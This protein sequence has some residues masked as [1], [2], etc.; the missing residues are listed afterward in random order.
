MKKVRVLKKMPFA[1][2][3]EK[4]SITQRFY[5]F[6]VEFLWNEHAVKQMISNGWL[7]WVEE[8]KSLEEKFNDY[9]KKQW[10]IRMP[11]TDLVNIARTH[12]LEVFDKKQKQLGMKQNHTGL[13]YI[14]KA[15]EN[16]GKENL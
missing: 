5:Y 2:I 8:D 14:R 16:D 10:Q 6:G 7:E 11:L 1:E 3:G 13:D 15:L 12:F 9:Q 4:L